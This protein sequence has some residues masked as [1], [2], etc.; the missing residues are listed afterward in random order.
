[1]SFFELPRFGV[2][3]LLTADSNRSQAS[4]STS[5]DSASWRFTRFLEGFGMT[6]TYSRYDQ[7]AHAI[8]D[9]CLWWVSDE[10]VVHDIIL[11]LATYL[12]SGFD[13]KEAWD[14]LH[15]TVSHMDA[16]Q[17]IATAKVLA[18]HVQTPHSPTFYEQAESLLNYLD[19]VARPE[20][21]RYVHDYWT[22]D[23]AEVVRVRYGP[24]VH[25]PS[26]RERSLSQWTERRYPSLE[27]IHA[28]AKNLELVYRDL[29]DLDNHIAW[30]VGQRDSPGPHQQPLPQEWQSLGHRDWREPN[31]H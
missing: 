17:K 12:H 15:L 28:F 13:Q 4:G 23:G 24:K 8:G 31:T 20:R 11:H 14:I 27:A 5:T 26:S 19:N 30:L 10:N 16:R 25:R 29:V 9:V 18:H 1:M 6:D 7:I 22:S 21:N 3:T 2:A